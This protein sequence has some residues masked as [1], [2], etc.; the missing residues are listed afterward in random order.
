MSLFDGVGEAVEVPAS[1]LTRELRPRAESFSCCFDSC[2]DLTNRCS[3]NLR[4][5]GFSS[6]IYDFPRIGF[7]DDFATAN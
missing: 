7:R 3:T 1:L 6:G 4:N 2:I 5:L